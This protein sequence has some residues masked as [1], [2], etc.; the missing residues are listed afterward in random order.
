MVRLKNRYLLVNILYPTTSTTTTDPF[1]PSNPTSKSLPGLVKFHQPTSDKVTP[2]LLVRIIK[3][4]VGNLFGDYGVGVIAG[5][6]SVKYLSPATSTLIIRVSRAHYRLVWAALT[7]ITTLPLPLPL[8]TA[9]GR[10]GEKRACVFGVVRVS[11]TIRKAEEE[12]IRRARASV[13]RARREEAG[14]G[15]ERIL[16]RDVERA[17]GG[18]KGWSEGGI[19]DDDDDED[20]DDDEDED[21]GQDGNSGGR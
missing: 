6:L 14:D 12:A 21:E 17:E 3:T 16:G 9:G 10:E 8:P 15:L 7:F 1:P 11:G 19:E 13:M 4:E 2:Q 18:G 5:S 20:G